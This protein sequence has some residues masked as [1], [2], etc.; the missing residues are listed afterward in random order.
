MKDPKDDLPWW[1]RIKR[2][3]SAR[4][5]S[6]LQQ[7]P[8][9]LD[10][11]ASPCD[12]LSVSVAVHRVLQEDPASRLGLLRQSHSSPADLAFMGSFAGG[13][14]SRAAWRQEARLIALFVFLFVVL[15]TSKSL[16]VS[17]AAVHGHMCAPLVIGAKNVLSI[18]FGMT[19]AA[20]RDGIPGLRQ[21]CDMHKALRVMPVAGCFC[22]AQILALHALKSFDAGS[23]KVI[24][25]VNLPLTAL[26]SWLVL[27]RRYSGRQWLAMLLL[28]VATTAFLQVRML[29]YFEPPHSDDAQPR[30]PAP[31][32]AIGML[33]FLTG[34]A[35][36]CLASI[37]A[38][39]F[40]KKR[41]DIPFYIQKTNLMIGELILAGVMFQLSVR[42]ERSGDDTC[43]WEQ[44]WAWRQ[45]P[46]ALVWFIHGWMAGLLVKRCSAL[47]KNISH[48][49]SALVTYFLPLLF[50][51]EERQHFWPCT[52]SALL[53]LIAVL[54]F[55]TVPPPP[56]ER[57]RKT[58][59]H[60]R[61]RSGQQKEIHRAN[62]EVVIT[63]YLQQHLEEQGRRR[64]ERQAAAS[65]GSDEP[66]DG[67]VQ[68]ASRLSRPLAVVP[69]SPSQSITLLVLCFILL[70]A[71]KPLLVTWAT[72]RKPPGER[73]ILGSFVLVQTSLSLMVG[74]TMAAAPSISLRPVRLS[75]HPEWCLRVRR[76]V[77]PAAV[78]QQLPISGCLCLSKF[79]LVMA[80][81]RLDAGTVRVFGQASL[82][83]VGVSSHLF[84]SKKYTAQ[85]WCSLVAIS[86]ALI[87]FYYVKAEVN[88][89]A[90]PSERPHNPALE[91]F[92]VLFILG[93]IGFNCLG[94]LLVEKF[95]KG[96]HN[97]L[98]VQKSQLLSGEVVVNIGLLIVVP[99]L[100][101]TPELR[102]AHSPWA[103]GFF[104]GWDGRVLLCAIVWIPSGWTTTMIVKRCSN[105]LKTIAQSASS[106][107][108]YVFTILPLSAGPRFWSYLVTKLGP[109]LQPEPISFP[110]LLLAITVMLAAITFGAD[111][112][113]TERGGQ[114]VAAAREQLRLG[115]A[116]GAAGPAG[117][118]GGAGGLAELSQ[119]SG[120]G[121]AAGAIDAQ[122]AVDPAYSKALLKRRPDPSGGAAPTA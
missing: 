24:A 42:S 95:L 16:A 74:L 69:T 23:L 28:L 117:A 79:L 25:Q 50:S 91:M 72:A 55:A 58:S 31:D 86:I 107:L 102:A 82:P 104:A 39:R 108:T 109:P 85:Q 49:I 101:S 36:S 54:V 13:S 80:L 48:I 67:R 88:Q 76:C 66:K 8:G 9:L 4:V 21:C 51:G 120:A 97:Q 114:A 106:V 46:V 60:S 30:P 89:K 63:Q 2:R 100:Q 121:G 29:F 77:E 5:G 43:S 20:C 38:E 78:L 81:G 115:G 44:I 61:S 92:G 84:F 33:L 47:V 122:W 118:C 35:L 12:V 18:S 65:T 83:L 59:M 26:L 14:G 37:F 57:S 19:L 40:L 62:S 99:L 98:H 15:D 7:V 111:R 96:N 113:S 93:S 119:R 68:S 73:F 3:L 6:S 75:L 52:L 27:G 94:A 32:K 22:A 112:A 70:D 103:R 87:T 71:T 41:Y 10:A 116:A 56:P 11:S 17:W 105:L 53:V 1:P 64:L 110:V 90:A 45:L 34:V